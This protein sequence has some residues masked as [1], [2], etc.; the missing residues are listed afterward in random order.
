MRTLLLVLTAAAF[1]AGAEEGLLGKDVLLRL[2]AL[3]QEYQP[4]LKTDKGRAAFERQ[5]E[6]IS[7]KLHRSLDKP[8]GVTDEHLASLRGLWD[9]TVVYDAAL[10]RVT[11][12]PSPESLAALMEARKGM[13]RSSQLLV[14]LPEVIRPEWVRR[15]GGPGG[16]SD[17]GGSR[18]P[19]GLGAFLLELGDALGARQTFDAA[20]AADPRDSSALAGRA[21]AAYNMGDFASAYKDARRAL[22]LDPNDRVALAALKLADGR[23]GQGGVPGAPAAG[24]TGASAPAPAAAAAPAPRTPAVAVPTSSAGALEAARW[25]REALAAMKLGDRAAALL[26]ADRALA[27]Y[28][29]N[30]VAHSVRARLMIQA[31]DY[32]AAFDAASAGLLLSPGDRTL[33]GLKARAANRLRQAPVAGEAAAQLLALDPAD[34]EGLANL[35]YA[36]GLSGDRGGMLSLL[37]KAAEADPQYQASLQSA[38]SM[39]AD[40][41]ELF[42]FPGEAP[43]GEVLAALRA[44]KQPQPKG[45]SLP[46]VGLSGLGGGILLAAAVLTLK[47]RL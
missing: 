19:P 24:A 14:Q 2:Q 33:L 32:R 25:N 35:A 16:P 43:P 15:E 8:T 29:D 3:R 12:S 5:L 11:K 47:R 9:A 44:A 34:P 46:W 6:S 13:A 42:L 31:R 17:E 23:G 22:E 26:A 37:R 18:R 27:A 41:A 39:P 45:F 30:P 38:L 40:A 10:S 7:R 28:P 21:A 4:K 1:A 36:H 20:A